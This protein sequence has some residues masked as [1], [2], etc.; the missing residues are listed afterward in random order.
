MRILII[1]ALSHTRENLK[2]FL[3]LHDDMEVVGEAS[4]GYEALKLSQSIQPDIIIMDINLPGMNGFDVTQKMISH[5][6]ASSIIL[7][8]VHLEAHDLRAAREAGAQVCIE[9][10]AGI[11]PIIK[12]ICSIRNHKI[13]QE[14][15]KNER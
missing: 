7:L 14:G 9:K 15:G 6:P 10:S 2:T 12:A 5:T 1:D 8:T 4:N 13:N 3:E 11:D